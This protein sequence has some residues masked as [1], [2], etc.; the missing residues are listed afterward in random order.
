MLGQHSPQGELF[1][2]DNIHLDHVGRG[3]I[4]G[5]IAQERHRL[6]RDRD[7]ADLYRKDWG[8]P[9]VPPS[10]LCLALILQAKD[11]VSD[12]EAIQRSAFDLRWK[13]ALGIDVDENLCA[14][15]TLQMFRAKLVLHDKYQKVFESS[16]ASCR[17]AGLLKKKKIDVAL[18]TT[19]IFGRGAVKDTFNLLS[20]QIVRVVKSVVELKDLDQKQLVADQGLGRHFGSSL[21]SQFDIEWDDDEQKR[22]VVAQLVADAHIALT[23]AKS[24]LR[25]YAADAEQ[26]ADLRSSRDLL[27]DLLLQDVDESPADSG[28]PCIKRGTKPNRIVSTTDPEMRHGRKSASKRFDGYK[29]SIAA[30]VEHGVILATDVIAGNAHDSEGAAE[31]AAQAGKNAKQIVANVLG[32]TAYGSSS[33]RKAI[34]KATKGAKVIAKVSKPSK[35]KS[36][37]FTVEDFNVDL[38]RGVAKCPAGKSSSACSQHKVTGVHRFTFSRKHC[39]SC[40]LRAKCTS[41]KVGSRKLSVSA[42][43]DALRKLRALQRT[44]GFKKAYRRRTRVEHRIARI[45]QLGARHARYFGRAKVTYQICMTAVVANLSVAMGALFRATCASGDALSLL[46]TTWADQLVAFFRLTSRAQEFAVSE[47]YAGRY[48]RFQSEMVTSRPSL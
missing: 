41:S 11:G 10:Q 1:R 16:I 17:R 48:R 38:K 15:S 33:T 31:L 21:K 27:A 30:E 6:F 23:I 36:I 45:V 35:P 8:R 4:Y 25:G 47:I 5:F 3:S 7:F 13:V 46:L 19:P 12:D 40:P 29:A 43:Y 22:A 26:T 37:D 2:P 20:D 28:D 44:S 39:T 14:K 24:A 18:D 32:D 34:T 9:S 42:N